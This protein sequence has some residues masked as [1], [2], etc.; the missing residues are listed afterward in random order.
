MELV[1]QKRDKFGKAVKALR[2]QGW[3]PAELY[4]HGVENAHLSVAV[5][6]FKKVFKAAGESTMIELVVEG[7]KHPVMIH[8]V[9]TD[10]VSDEVTG[11]D[12]YQVRLDEKL[13][14]KVPLVFVGESVGVKEKQ[15]TLIKAISEIEVEAFPQDIPH[16]I[17]VNI[18]TLVD[19]GSSIKV[20]E[21]PVGKA[22][23]VL[24]DTE[25][26]VATITARMTEE[27]EAKL[28]AAA[29]VSTIKTEGDEKK[30]AK[31]AADAATPADAAAAPATAGKPAAAPAK[32][33][34]K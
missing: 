31:A 20:K 28:A 16:S 34:K 13:K 6:D 32:D 26:V 2:S 11:I 30:E 17:E 23:K 5:K 22:V 15:G 29:D 33:A 1:A 8:E 7:K 3:L 14:I 18:S 21:L 27:E 24:A 9:I 12:F 10:P 19:I 4:G 25:F